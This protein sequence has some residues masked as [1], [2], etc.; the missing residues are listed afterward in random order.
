MLTSEQVRAARA[1]LRWEQK[2]LAD[3]CGVSLPSI[4]RLETQRG[5]LAAQPR[6]VDAIRN[7]LEAA[8]VIFIDQNGNGYGVRLRDRQP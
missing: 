3:A 6:T 5:E 7:A 2:E 4:K 1:L 8:G